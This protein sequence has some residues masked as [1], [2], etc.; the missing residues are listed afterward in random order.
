MSVQPATLGMTGTQGAQTPGKGDAF[1]EVKMSDFIKLMITELQNQDPMN[2]MDNSQML[3]QIGQIR[4]I[5]SNDKLTETLDSLMLGQSI[6]MASGMIGQ[7]ISAMSDDKKRVDGVVERVTIEDGQAK[8]KVIQTVPRTYDES[9]GKWIEEHEVEHTV[10][11]KNVT[12]I[13]NKD[14][15]AGNVDTEETPDLAAQLTIAEKLIGRSILGK[16]DEDKVV[17]GEVLR[18]TVEEGVPKLVLTQQIP[19]VFDPVTLQ[20]QTPATS[21]DHQISLENIA[22][23]LPNRIETKVVSEAG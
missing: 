3:A 18:V 6:S 20:E 1:S 16:S 21:V 22:K 9:L 10:S 7:K 8:L 19:A 4:E 13:L 12:E 17:T 11:M 23:I 5:S 15:E 14:I 2:P